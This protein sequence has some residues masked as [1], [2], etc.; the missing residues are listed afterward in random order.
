[1]QQDLIANYI[2]VDFKWN[3]KKRTLIYK[4]EIDGPDS[5]NFWDP[6]VKTESF[7]SLNSSLKYI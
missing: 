1:M 4:T 2:T 5:N 6:G 3:N 7:F